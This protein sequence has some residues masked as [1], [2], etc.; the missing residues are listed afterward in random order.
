M[1][2]DDNPAIL[3]FRCPKEL[4]GLI[5]PP[6]PAAHGLPT[7]LKAMPS[8]ALSG[9]MAGEDNTVKRC[10]PFVDAM[11]CGF[12]IPLICDVK[13]ENGEFTWDN[14]LPPGGAVDFLR[15]PIGLHDPGQ[16]TGTPLF[17]AEQFVIKFHNL[18]TIEAPKGYSLLFTH[19]VNRFDLPFTTLTGLVECDATTT[20]GSIFRH[21]G[22]IRIS[23]ACCRRARRSCNASRSRGKVGWRAPRRSMRTRRGGRTISQLQFCEREACTA[24]NSGVRRQRLLLRSDFAAALGCRNKQLCGRHKRRMTH[25]RIC[26]AARI[27]A[28]SGASPARRLPISKPALR[29]LIRFKASFKQMS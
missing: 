19:P 12:L 27:T 26:G 7:W 23:P 14:E 6:V 3:T 17:D 13:V 4:D 2:K 9:L 20:P 5:P 16:V 22:T 10:P 18:W 28:R 25:P 11:T 8:T 29:S 24:A 1:S 21:A 15:S